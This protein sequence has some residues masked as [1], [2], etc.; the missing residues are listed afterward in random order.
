MLLGQVWYVVRLREGRW[1]SSFCFCQQKLAWSVRLFVDA[2]VK[3]MH[4][5]SIDRNPRRKNSNWK[6]FNQFPHFIIRCGTSFVFSCWEGLKKQFVSLSDA[7]NTHIY[8]YLCV[9][10]IASNISAKP[11]Q[12]L[13]LFIITWLK[14][15]HWF[16][17]Q[18]LKLWQI[19]FLI[20]F[21]RYPQ[22][23]NH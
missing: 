18:Y 1:R 22:T 6:C 13:S 16:F 5:K 9:S 2:G 20:Q 7:L 11:I 3:G 4:Q 15:L 19:Y 10:F 23:A 21:D 12:M 8:K 14:L 17:K